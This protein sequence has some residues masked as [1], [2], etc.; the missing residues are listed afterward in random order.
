MLVLIVTDNCLYNAR[1]TTQKINKCAAYESYLSQD[2][3]YWG[4]SRVQ[5]R[6][7]DTQITI[8]QDK[9][10]T[11]TQNKGTASKGNHCTS[12]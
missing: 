4:R 1:I 7:H 12:K 9:A 10:S 11:G 3:L 8:T 5:S 6:I 2:P